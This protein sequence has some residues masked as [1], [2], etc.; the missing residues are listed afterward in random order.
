VRWLKWTAILL[1]FGFVSFVASIEVTDHLEEDNRFCIA[2]HL[3]EDIF[4]NFMTDTPRLVALAG[5][6]LHKGEVKCIDCHIGATHTDK[7]IV[8]AMAGW[9]TVQY[10]MG[11]FKEPDHLRFPLGDRTCLKCHT[12]GGQSKT[13]AG[14]FHNEPNHR[15]MHFECVGCHQSHPVRDPSVLFLEEAIVRP[16]CHEC[17]K[18]DGGEESGEG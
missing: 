18:E 9:D 2:C 13:R 16:V 6:H 7:L 12:D 14:A 5:A 11:N 1:A 10:F 3:H 8:K 4:K 17:H 15:N